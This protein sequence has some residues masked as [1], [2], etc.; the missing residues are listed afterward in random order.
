[1]MKIYNNTDLTESQITS[2]QVVGVI[3]NIW[4]NR[5]VTLYESDDPKK[6]YM[7]GV[8]FDE[9]LKVISHEEI[10]LNEKNAMSEWKHSGKAIVR[11]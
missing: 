2:R 11:D 3:K 5:L 9:K 6:L 10:G 7:I 8:S 4:R 1:M